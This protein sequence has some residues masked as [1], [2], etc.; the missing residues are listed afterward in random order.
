[1][2]ANLCK[3]RGDRLSDVEFFINKQKF[4]YLTL[5]NKDDGKPRE[6]YYHIYKNLDTPLSKNDYNLYTPILS[7]NSCASL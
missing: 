5:P 3:E 4:P 6:P 2:L 1:M 7:T